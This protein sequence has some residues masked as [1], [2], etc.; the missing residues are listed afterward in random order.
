MTSRGGTE[1]RRLPKV[2]PLAAPR[3]KCG[4]S[5]AGFDF[6]VIRAV[7]HTHRVPAWPAHMKAFPLG[8]PLNPACGVPESHPGLAFPAC[9]VYTFVMFIL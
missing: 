4:R 1:F 2:P 8:R 5:Q 9:R 7:E 3:V 6:P